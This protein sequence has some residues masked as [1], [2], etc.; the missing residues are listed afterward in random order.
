M[1]TPKTEYFVGIDAI[2]NLTYNKNQNEV[3]LVLA[4]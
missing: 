2:S 3:M 4:L 1:I